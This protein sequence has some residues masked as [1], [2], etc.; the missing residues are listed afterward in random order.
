MC[1][2]VSLGW[3]NGEKEFRKCPNN[4]Q[5][6]ARLREEYKIM[7][8]IFDKHLRNA[9]RAY[10]RKLA[11]HIEDMNTNDPVQFCNQI[12]R[13][14]PQKNSEIPMSVM[15]KTGQCLTGLTLLWIHGNLISLTSKTNWLSL[16]IVCNKLK[17]AKAVGLDLIPNEVLKQ[18]D[19]RD[20]IL[21]FNNK[22]FNCQ[23]IPSAWQKSVIK[24]IPKSASK[25]PCVPLNYRGISLMSCFYKIYSGLIDNRIT[26]HC[27]NNTLIVDEQNGFRADRSC[28]DYIFCMSSVI[29]NNIEKSIVFA[30]FIDMRKAFDWITRDMLLYKILFQLGISGKLYGAIK[31]LY[32]FSEACL[33]INNYKTDYFP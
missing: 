1:H 16:D 5:I 10:T 9:E 30:A 3:L 7:Q 18:A 31:S 13:L 23:L 21:N 20:I 27:E 29:R 24:Q 2:Q 6:K 17:N 14:G 32:S 28:L 4:T 15:R 33:K 11:D 19:M 12:N 26:S 8:G 25:D 22:Y